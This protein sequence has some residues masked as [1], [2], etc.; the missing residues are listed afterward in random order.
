MNL[1]QNIDNL[2]DKAG[3]DPKKVCLANG[4]IKGAAC[5]KCKNPMDQ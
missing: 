1:T 4:C 2:E 3:I 5:G